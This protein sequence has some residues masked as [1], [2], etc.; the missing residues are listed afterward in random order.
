M[1][2]GD[3]GKKNYDIVVILIVFFR[4]YGYFVFWIKMWDKLI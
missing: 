1:L 3:G 2:N 4:K